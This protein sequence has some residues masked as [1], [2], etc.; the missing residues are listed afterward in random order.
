MAKKLK[1]IFLLLFIPVFLSAED[2]SKKAYELIY[3]DVQVLKK[4]LQVLEEKIGQNAVEIETVKNQVRELQALVKL[5][6]V[7]QANVREGIKNVPSQYQ[8]L[9]DKIDQ[10]NILLTKIS[11]NLLTMKGSA[12]P[13]TGPG[14]E[15]KEGQPSQAEKKK[16]EQKKEATPAEKKPP[17]PPQTSLS[18]Q[19]VYNS[20]YADYLKGSFEMAIEGFKV[21]RENFPDSP[22]ADNALYWI[23][24]CAY[25][26][27]KFSAAIDGFND[28]ILNYP[29][30]DKIA[31]AYLKKGLALVE[32]K[33][34]DEAAVVFRLLITKYPLEEEAR[35]A[36][37][38]LKELATK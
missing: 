25:S 28:L 2:K 10:M 11:E 27:R 34:K 37:E 21:Y 7:D 38:K 6:Q 1:G 8:F 14:Q 4:Q 3:E 35:I 22:L 31:A 26:Q 9:M 19:D 18:P 12:T 5:L 17:A 36:Q 13:A 29:Q 30:S 23:G 33:R 20:A 24:E 16:P 15:E 32:L